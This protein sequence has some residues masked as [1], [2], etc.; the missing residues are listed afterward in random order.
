MGGD[1]LVLVAELVTVS[2]LV[3]GSHALRVRVGLSLFYALLGALAALM[4][5]V[6]D[7]GMTVQFAGITFV[8]GSTVF[9]TSLLE[10]V[11]VVY[12]F[13]GPR[14]TRVAI[15]VVAGVSALV[16][17]VAAALHEQ[18][19]LAGVMTP[20]PIPVPSL[21]INSASVATT[22]VDFLFL[23]IAWEFLG[24]P[25]LYRWLRV[26]LTFLGVMWL[27]VALFATGAFAG[28][29]AYLSIMSGTL[30][31]RLVV[32]VFTLPFL[33]GYLYWQGARKGVSMESRPILAVLQRVAQVEADLSRAQ[34]EIA[35]RRKAEEARER[36][37][38][39]LRQA[40]AEVRTL[41]GLLPICA[42]CKKI[43]DDQG[44]WNSIETYLRQHTEA[45]LT[46]GICPECQKKLYPGFP[47]EDRPGTS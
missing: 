16:P 9:Y 14:A 31:T 46:H 36:T 24:K 21:R 15:A 26:F 42:N 33:L 5:W 37:I 6:T 17:L 39:D 27:D 11:F 35:L 19:R 2:L 41:R 45:E 44:Y 34:V 18:A 10:G 22:V 8:V 12:V 3:F 43:R 28:T 38:R 7:A 1:A 40:L 25:R 29:S 20:L 4:S 23:A 13:G 47:P 32:S 30:S